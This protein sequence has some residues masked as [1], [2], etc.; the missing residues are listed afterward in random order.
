MCRKNPCGPDAGITRRDQVRAADSYLI[1]PQA[2]RLRLEWLESHQF[3]RSNSHLFNLIDAERKIRIYRSE[4]TIVEQGR[5]NG[6]FPTALDRGRDN[7]PLW[8]LKI[9]FWWQRLRKKYL[10]RM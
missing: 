7:K 10:Y 3:D 1:N 9:R 2:A 5:M 6:L 8:F 4:P